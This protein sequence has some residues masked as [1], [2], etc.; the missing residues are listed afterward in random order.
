MQFWKTIPE[1]KKITNV[2]KKIINTTELIGK[3]DQSFRITEIR[4]KIPSINELVI[5][6]YKN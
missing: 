1:K 5:E 2:D 3:S 4:N 6:N